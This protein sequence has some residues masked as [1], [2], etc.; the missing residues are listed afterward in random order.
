MLLRGADRDA[1]RNVSLSESCTMQ[2]LGWKMHARK[3]QNLAQL[4]CA[5]KTRLSFV[6]NSPGFSP[7]ALWQENKVSESVEA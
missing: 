3:L 2:G 6:C 7:P 5:K 1:A 4:R